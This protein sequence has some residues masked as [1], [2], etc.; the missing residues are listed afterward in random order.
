[1]TTRLTVRE[2]L[3]VI[4]TWRRRWTVARGA[5]REFDGTRFGTAEAARLG[6]VRLI[7]LETR[8]DAALVACHIAIRP[9]RADDR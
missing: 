3:G 5:I 1:M 2:N 4:R 8:L 9:G 7:A 6:K